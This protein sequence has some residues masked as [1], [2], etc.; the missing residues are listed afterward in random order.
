MTAV[1]ESP[2]MCE[3]CNDERAVSAASVPGVPMTVAYGKRC[4]EA[5]VHPYG[6]LVAATAD[7]G[8]LINASHWWREMVQRTCQYLKVSMAQFNEDVAKVH[9]DTRSN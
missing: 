4:L 9:A 7:L 5:N 3:V 1:A 8:G 2:W 6:V